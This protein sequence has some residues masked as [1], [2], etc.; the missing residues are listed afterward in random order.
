[1]LRPQEDGEDAVTAANGY[2]N[3]VAIKVG[4]PFVFKEFG[5]VFFHDSP[6]MR[7]IAQ[8]A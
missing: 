7:P 8:S 1:L 4:A 6:S 2:V 3:G 5:A